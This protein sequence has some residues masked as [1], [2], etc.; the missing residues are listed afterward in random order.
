MARGLLRTAFDQ[1]SYDYASGQLGIASVLDYGATGDGIHDDTAAI[2]RALNDASV[3]VFPSLTYFVTGTLNP[4][5]DQVLMIFGKFLVGANATLWNFDGV[6][7]TQIVGTLHIMDPNGIT[8]GSV[9]AVLFG[10]GCEWLLVS[11][12]YFDN[13]AWACEMTDISESHFVDIVGR[14]CRGDGLFWGGDPCNV[15]DNVFDSI[16]FTGTTNSIGTAGSGLHLNPAA[17]G[18]ITGNHIGRLTVVSLSVGVLVDDGGWNYLSVDSAILTLCNVGWLETGNMNDFVFTYLE[19]S[20]NNTGWYFAPNPGDV[21]AKIFVGTLVADNNQN[22][23]VRVGWSLG[24]YIGRAHLRS[25]GGYGLHTAANTTVGKV[26]IGELAAEGNTL[27]DV[28]ANAGSGGYNPGLVLNSVVTTHQNPWQDITGD[29]VSGGNVTVIANT[30]RAVT[31]SGTTAGTIYWQE[32]TDYPRKVVTC[33]FDGYENDTA[34]DQS[35]TFPV[36][37]GVSATVSTNTTGLTLS[38]S[39]TVLTITAPDNTDTYSGVVEVIGI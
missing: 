19:C 11:K 22:D 13:L 23:G 39:T 15:H 35:L 32:T 5:S 30:G 36:S 7:H 24:I 21:V 18:T 17:Q 6:V 9:P 4:R 31:V 16:V 3:V 12:M 37:F 20:H 26:M 10:G 34:T 38:A 28:L 1:A 27:G 33:V 25:N 14:N 2:Q 8:T 29:S